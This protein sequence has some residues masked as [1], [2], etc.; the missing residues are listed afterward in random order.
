MQKAEL[1]LV[2]RRLDLLVLLLLLWAKFGGPRFAASNP[3]PVDSHIKPSGFSATVFDL[4]GAF[5]T[6]RGVVA[7]R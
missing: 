7:E 3:Q 6:F 2:R 5:H 4:L 1:F